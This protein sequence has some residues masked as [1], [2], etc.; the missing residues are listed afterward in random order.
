MKKVLLLVFCLPFFNVSAQTITILD[1]DTKFP[2]RNVEVFSEN[3]QV[4]A[5][6]NK[7][8]I[9]DISAFADDEVISFSHLGYVDYDILKRQIPLKGKIYLQSVEHQLEEVFLS[10][11]KRV[12]HRQRIAEQIDILS[13]AEIQQLQAQTAADVLSTMPGIKVQK[14][15]SGG[16]SP[17]LRGMEANRILLVVDGV[18]MNNAIYR[19]GHL[20]NSITVSPNQLDRTE[21]IFGPSSVMYGSDALGGVIHFYTKKPKVSTFF[22]TEVDLLSRYNSVNDE[23]TLQAGV[24]LSFPKWA[25]YTSISR[26]EFGDIRMGKKRNHGFDTWGLIPTYSSNN[27]TF[28]SDEETVNGDPNVQRRTGYDQTDFL[29]KFYVPIS[30]NT[31]LGVNLQYSTSSNINRFDRL[32][33]KRDGKLRFAEW[34]YGPQKRFLVSTQLGLKPSLT[35]MNKGTITLAYQNIEESRINRK[36]G[37]LNRTIRKEQVDVVSLNADFSLPLTKD[38][39]RILSYGLEFTHN[40]VDSNPT[41]EVLAI[42]GN[43]IVG[44]SDYFPVQARYADGGS[45]YSTGAVYLN[46]RQDISKTS[47]LNSGIRFTHTRLAANWIDQTFIRLADQDIL[48]NNSAVTAT[49]GYIFKPTPN[50]QLNGVLSSG[51]RSPNIDDIGKVREKSGEVT[52]PNVHLKPEYAYN[53]EVGLLR[54]FNKKKMYVGA[55]FYYTLLDHYIMRTNFTMNGSSTILFDGEEGNVV[56]NVNMDKAGIFGFTSTVKGVLSNELSTHASLTYTHGKAYDTD[57]P[58]SSIPPLFAQVGMRYEK[59]KVGG[60]IDYVF[61][62]HKKPNTYNLTEG[63]DRFEDTPFDENTQNYYGTPQWATLD[64]NL[65]YKLSKQLMLQAAVDN[66]FDIHYK[67]YASGISAPGRGFKIALMGKF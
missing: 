5:I 57:E 50:W 12:E 7:N 62:A 40:D 63:I 54:Y 21:V 42:E 65:S 28:Y 20:Q 33:E 67:E 16:G 60:G 24:E 3:K 11:S 25:S 44:I 55:T 49:L 47:T 17:I 23:V 14:S 52:V 41:G 48:V 45:S 19:H 6:S 66:V 27:D 38:E 22:N 31:D 9:V 36:F 64:V 30:N 32:I 34:Y 13:L 51:F 4:K 2:I 26:S 29:Q 61:N 59:G 58:L 35:W 56:A 1:K 39:D 53:A 37:S 46:Y 10:T 8:G 43:Q 18:R 15:Q